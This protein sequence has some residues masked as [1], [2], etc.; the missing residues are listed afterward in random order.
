MRSLLLSL[1]LLSYRHQIPDPTLDRDKAFSHSGFSSACYRDGK[2]IPIR[3]IICSSIHFQTRPVEMYYFGSSRNPGQISISVTFRAI[4]Q[5]DSFP[6]LDEV[7][8]SCV[9]AESVG[10]KHQGR[11]FIVFFGIPD[12]G[13]PVLNGGEYELAIFR[14]RGRFLLDLPSE[15]NDLV[16]GKIVL[17]YVHYLCHSTRLT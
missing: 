15:K 11:S 7:F 2:L 9:R 13:E 16:M 6:H 10:F 8:G 17:E 1:W 5:G 14:R 12:A 4:D 3:L